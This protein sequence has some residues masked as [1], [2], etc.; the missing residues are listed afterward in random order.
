MPALV[1]LPPAGPVRPRPLPRPPCPRPTLSLAI[2]ESLEELQEV[3]KD[4]Y[5]STRTR[6]LL[7]RAMVSMQV[8]LWSREHQHEAAIGQRSYR[9]R[10]LPTA[11]I[12]CSSDAS[13]SIRSACTLA[14]WHGVHWRHG[15]TSARFQLW[16][17]V[18]QLLC[19]AKACQAVVKLG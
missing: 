6:C 9:S 18:L 8:E 11:L 17:R 16:R 14:D 7:Y 19:I 10:V 1:V 15:T 3:A 4:L 5:N 13:V 12:C 2:P